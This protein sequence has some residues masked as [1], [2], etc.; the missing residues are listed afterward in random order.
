MAGLILIGIAI[1][2]LGTQEPGANRV[3]RQQPSTGFDNSRVQ[4]IRRW[5]DAV[6]AGNS[7]SIEVGADLGSLQRFLGITAETNYRNAVPEERGELAAQIRDALATGEQARLFREFEM[8]AGVLSTES[9]VD[10]PTGVVLAQLRPRDRSTDPTTAQVNIAFRMGDANPLVTGWEVNFDPTAERAEKTDP[11]ARRRGIPSAHPNIAAPESVSAVFGGRPITIKETA[12]VALGHL[13]DTSPESRAEIDRLIADLLDLDGPG[14]LANRSIDRLDEI[15][16]PTIP[17]LLNQLYE[18]QG[19]V[20][21]NNLS[22]T[23]IDRALRVLTG[24]AFDYQPGNHLVQPAGLELRQSS[25]EEHR[26]SALKQWYAWWYRYHDRDYAAL[27]D[28]QESL[29]PVKG[30]IKK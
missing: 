21:A 10:S 8:I 2:T 7:F 1:K 15:G 29:P 25:V 16:R 23:R 19:D 4:A 5:V 9:M 3:A 22:L 13:P 28:K 11:A 24:R 27:I 14:T 26:L 6:A 18:L 20:I 30:T 17:R 12:P